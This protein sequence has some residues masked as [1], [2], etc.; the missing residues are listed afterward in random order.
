MQQGLL[1]AVRNNFTKEEIA[2]LFK[3]IILY[4]IDLNVDSGRVL[5]LC[6]FY[7]NDY[8]QMIMDSP[9]LLCLLDIKYDDIP[10]HINDTIEIDRILA[11][12]RLKIGH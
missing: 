10:L 2:D 6:E 9:L 5:N 3:Y 7:D 12:W 11:K 1:R 8:K 4:D